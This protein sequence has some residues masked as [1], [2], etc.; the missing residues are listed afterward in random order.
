MRLG[1]I[2]YGNI[3]TLTGGYIY[4]RILVEYLQSRG[5]LIDI[6]SLPWRNY[7]RHLLDNFSPGLRFDLADSSYDILLQDELNHPS[8]FLFN[9]N[10]KRN[11]GLP[12]VAIVHQVSCRQ[13]RNRLL[14][15]IYRAV[16]K[17]YLESVDAMI[18]NS[19]TTRRTVETLIGDKRPSIVAFPAGD[20]L[21]HLP[22]IDLIESRTHDGGPLRLIFVGNVLP[23]KGLLPLI[24]GLSHL[25]PEIWHLTVVGSLTMDDRYVRKIKRLIRQ[26][27]LSRQIDIA[28]PK[29]GNELAGLFAQS[30]VF[31]MPYSHESF[32]MAYLEAMAFALPVVGSSQGALSEFVIPAHNG[33][34]IEPD[35]VESV[36]ACI[37]TLHHDRQQLLKMS[38]AAFQTYNERPTWRDT[39][40][41][42]HRFLSNL[43]NHRPPAEKRV[44]RRT[45]EGVGP[46]AAGGR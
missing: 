29:D 3:D 45:Q 38:N 18:F 41:S 28:G 11:T 35:D 30:H 12:M 16:E 22:S 5:Y 32:G 27:N 14:N 9:R 44:G 37:H 19:D 13:P 4:D 42:I 43:I 2:I 33:F 17:R 25:S 39:M 23:H 6:I 21:G 7:G 26:K 8:L 36:N 40:D 1:L 24:I 46:R 31:V 10:L 34:L 15:R 20:R